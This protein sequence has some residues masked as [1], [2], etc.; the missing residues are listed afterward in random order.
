MPIQQSFNSGVLSRQVWGRSDLVKFASGA[1]TMRNIICLSH[2][3]ASR[4]S[5]SEFIYGAEDNA[6]KGLLYGFEFSPDQAYMLEFCDL[7]IRFLKDGGIILK[8]GVPYELTSPYAEADLPD[9]D[10]TSIGDTTYIFHPNYNT[11]LLV[12][13]DHD[14]WTITEADYI[15]GPFLADNISETGMN[16]GVNWDEAARNISTID[17]TSELVR[18][19][20]TTSHGLINGGQVG[21]DAIVGTTELN[22]F[23][24]IVDPIDADTYEL[25]DVKSSEVT[26]YGSAGTSRKVDTVTSGFVV[27]DI[28]GVNGGQGFLISDVGRLIAIYRDS[29]TGPHWGIG[30]IKGLNST[31]S[32]I[33]DYLTSWIGHDFGSANRTKIWKLGAWSDT[34]GYPRT[35][36][37]DNE[38]L[39]QGGTRTQPSVLN[40]S[41]LGVY[42]S[43]Q[44]SDP[45]DSISSMSLILSSKRSATILWL[46]SGNK[47]AAGTNLAEQW[48]SSATGSG[49]ITPLSKKTNIGSSNGVSNVKPEMIGDRII[50]VQRHGKVIRELIYSLDADNFGGQELQVLAEHLTRN[51]TVTAMA[52]QRSPYKVIWFVRDDGKLLGLTYYPEQEVYGFHIHDL[53]GNGIVESIAVIPGTA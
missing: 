53:G 30:R 34:T 29:E 11:R 47:F 24:F 22:N 4:R 33:A 27:S 31:T 39:W 49:A 16:E 14:D 25:R 38:R 12:R 50:L 48:L 46:E 15:D 44:V 1:R 18:V 5:G 52:Y 19:T 10:F 6:V 8:L 23:V 28:T 26:A 51:N 42:L 36:C 20:T 37:L 32:V 17:L 3:P 13:L 45:L 40:G 43:N 41:V 7:K 9:L 21:L 35:G 2:G